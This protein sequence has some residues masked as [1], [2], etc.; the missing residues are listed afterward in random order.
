VTE[1]DAKRKRIALSMKGE[2][3]RV[4]APTQKVKQVEEVY[5]T[6]DL[7]SALNALKNKFKTK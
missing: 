7:N 1:V 4:S 6:N 5:D 3:Q 2:A